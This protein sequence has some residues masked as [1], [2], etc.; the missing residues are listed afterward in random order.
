MYIVYL[1]LPSLKINFK[2]NYPSFHPVPLLGPLFEPSFIPVQN[3]QDPINTVLITGCRRVLAKWQI[4]TGNSHVIPTLKSF[5]NCVGKAK[6]LSYR[7]SD[8]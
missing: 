5:Q 3:S 1:I 8:N 7:C 4:A 2:T 6:N